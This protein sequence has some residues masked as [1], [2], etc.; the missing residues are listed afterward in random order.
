MKT[1]S[2][3][4]NKVDRDFLV[5]LLEYYD[6]KQKEKELKGKISSLFSNEQEDEDYDNENLTFSNLCNYIVRK[7]FS[8]PIFN[9]MGKLFVEV[10]TD[11]LTDHIF[12]TMELELGR[13]LP[14]FE[15]FKNLERLKSIVERSFTE[16]LPD[17]KFVEEFIEEI[18]KILDYFGLNT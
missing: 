7:D 3:T 12:Q 4:F 2:F 13:F 17:S 15:I 6:L 14:R 18:D 11:K 8:H 10:S 9:K 1:V 5:T 16:Q